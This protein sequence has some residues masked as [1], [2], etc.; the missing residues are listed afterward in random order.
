MESQIAFASSSSL[1]VEISEIFSPS[2]FVA[3]NFFSALLV[4]LE[5]TDH[6]P[7]RIR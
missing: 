6:A 3:T 2:P 4:L 5:T 7:S 1:P